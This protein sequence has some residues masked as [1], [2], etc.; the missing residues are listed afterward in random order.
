MCFFCF[1]SIITVSRVGLFAAFPVVARAF[2]HRV[3]RFG[4]SS[5]VRGDELHGVAVMPAVARAP[6]Y[7]YAA[8]VAGSQVT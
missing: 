8:C 4:A 5:G 1:S 6:S 3:S 7:A 2:Q